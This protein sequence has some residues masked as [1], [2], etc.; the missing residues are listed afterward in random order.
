[1]EGI[2]MRKSAPATACSFRS[3]SGL[4]GADSV[5][6]TLDGSLFQRVEWQAIEE[7][8]AGGDLACH[9]RKY[10]ALLLFGPCRC[11]RIFKAPVR[12]DRLAR[13][14]WT[15]FAGSVV[16]DG[17]D[18]IHLWCIW[19]RKFVPAFAAQLFQWIAGALDLFD[20]QRIDGAARMAT[21]AIRLET[22]FT[23]R[24]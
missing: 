21:G 14:D 18:E 4:A 5:H 7:V 23:H 1:M 22:T 8:D 19:R 24:I 2:L 3:E 15:N 13:P 17:N 20:S 6:F 9:F 11:S 16:A 12:R 10:R